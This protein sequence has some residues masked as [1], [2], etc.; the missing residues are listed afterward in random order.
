MPG[1]QSNFRGAG[2]A[3]LFLQRGQGQR[4]WDV[5]G[6]DFI[7]FTL[8]AGPGILGHA[9]P[10]IV[11]ALQEQAARLCYVAAGAAQTTLEVELAELIHRHVPCAEWTRFALSG[12]E[13][14]QLAIRLARGFTGRRYFVRFDGHYHGT[15][16]NVFGGVLNPDAS[17]LPFAIDTPDDPVRSAGR[18]PNARQE[19][20]LLPW[21]DA[22]LLERFLARH[23]H[24]VG[25]V[26]MEAVLCN[27][28]CCPPRPGYL[29]RVR[30]LCDLHGCLLC[31]DEVITGFRMSL[32]GAQAALGVTPD[33]ATF[34]KAIGGGMP[35][36][37]VAGR[38]DIL[39]QLR[40]HRV[41]AGGTFNAAPLGLAA[42]VATLT[43]LAAD[44]G[45]AYH[46]IAAQQAKLETVLRAVFERAGHK[47]LIQ[48]PNGVLFVEFV[49]LEVAWTPQELAAADADRMPRLRA[50]A[51]DEGL[52]LAGGNRF[53]VSTALSDADIDEVSSR[54]ARA[55]AKLNPP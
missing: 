46:R 26:L 15:A 1:R 49:D 55:L 12:T 19:C 45:A 22:G 28:G 14:V 36:S 24:D 11:A 4:Y 40:D 29:Q 43:E 37:A 2:T 10:R 39:A 8:G 48:G 38:A 51:L 3:P 50:L 7:D 47:V 52:L 53:F 34:G 25:L 13:A 6:R 5:D 30:E 32:G 33:L 16:D 17:A 31:F 54:L 27:A 20:F 21:N 42:A 35:V 18:A 41:L 44:S 9:H 23:G